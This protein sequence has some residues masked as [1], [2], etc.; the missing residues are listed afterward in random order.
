MAIHWIWLGRDK[1]T[2]YFLFINTRNSSGFRGR[3]N[4][5]TVYTLLVLVD[6]VIMER[7]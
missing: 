1:Q 5:C 2:G 3:V 6:F 4:T 7:R